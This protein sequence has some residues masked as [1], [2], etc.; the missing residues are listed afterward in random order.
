VRDD[1]GEHDDRVGEEEF[2]DED[3]GHLPRAE[4]VRRARTFLTQLAAD[5]WTQSGFV[6]DAARAVLGAGASPAAVRATVIELYLSFVDDDLVTVLGPGFASHYADSE[7]LRA[8]IVAAWP[9]GEAEVEPP[10]EDMPWLAWRER[11]RT[12][13]GP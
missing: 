11:D 12:P 10:I 7:R 2:L 3:M 4:R 5:D 8:D 1:V 13:P 6:I 9:E